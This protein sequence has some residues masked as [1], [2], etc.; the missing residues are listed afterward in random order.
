M[1]FLLSFAFFSRLV[2]LPR[3]S[4]AI[5]ELRLG[6]VPVGSMHVQK[7][8]RRQRAEVTCASLVLVGSGLSD[9]RDGAVAFELTNHRFCGSTAPLQ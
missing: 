4:C 2:Y 3:A 8:Y 5:L 7:V 6:G 9:G 1:S